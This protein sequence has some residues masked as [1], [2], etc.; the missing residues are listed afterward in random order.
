[1][2]NY[3][4]FQSK[5]SY[6]PTLRLQFARPSRVFMILV[7]LISLIGIPTINAKAATTITFIA[8][9]FL[10]R[11]ADTSININVIPASAIDLYYEYKVSSGAYLPTPTVS[12]AAGE[13]CNVIISDLSPDTKYYYHM[14]YHVAGE[15]DW[16][17]RSEHSFHTQRAPGE[18]FT[19]VVTSDTHSG[20]SGNYF[21]QSRYSQTLAHFLAD[22]PDLW[23]DVGDSFATDYKSTLAQ[24]QTAY[25]NM[26][27]YIK[28]VS[29]D[30]PFFQVLG[31][32]E[33][34]MGWNLDDKA[35]TS[36]T[37]P[38]LE[39]N[40]RR[41]IFPNPKPDS[42]YSGNTDTSL[43]Y[44]DDDHLRE[45]YYAFTWGDA[46]FI[47]LDPYWYTMTWPQED[48]TYP[49]G[50]EEDTANETR[51][52]RWD[53][54]LG[55]DQYLWLKDTLE[56]STAL[57]KFIFIHHVT[58]GI[59]PYGRGGTEI[60]GYFE[61]GGNNWDGTW[62]WDTHRSDAD[63]RWTTPIHQLL[64]QNNVTML[65]H[66]HDHFYAK[67]TLD[68]IVYQEIPMP[69]ATDG[70]WGFANEQTS[71]SYVDEYPD[72]D[73]ILYY[74]GAE[75]YPN[76]GHLRVTVSPTAGVTVDYVDMNDGSITATYTI[77]TPGPS[78]TLTTAVAPAGGGA[79]DPS[80]GDHSYSEGAIV[81]VTATPASGYVF[82]HWDGD[83]TGTGACQVTMN[84]NKTVTAYFTNAPSILGDVNGDGTVN[85][86]DALIVLS[87]DV[88][89]DIS[90]FCPANC[91]DVNDDGLVNSTDALIILSYD[92][93]MS[94]P[95]PVGEQGCPASVTPCPGCNP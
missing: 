17:T 92:V 23:I 69:A 73:D 24:Y 2:N 3:F 40:A 84:A 67:Q 51:G 76:S 91:G 18:T 20:L 59:I 62:G 80:A 54:T 55:I 65:F 50:G 7:L 90:Q 45:D 60:A 49:F 78:Y 38:I 22:D 81:E 56:N 94:T 68:D 47:A 8:E 35:D 74:D 10:S 87:G 39:V 27:N 70:Y 66:G 64:A 21:S 95:F 63:A 79:I 4:L 32:H 14:K 89:I 72:P 1:M 9:E 16:V 83:C 86:T 11:P 93:G 25:K 85:S 12:A 37:Q 31:N 75:E 53:W 48:S 71:G 52:N 41:A 44:I 19:F 43:T 58:G 34:E 46:L 77:P 36:Q 13:P 15:T 30:V 29:G 61:W 42:F 33:Q 6:N 5:T 57:Y 82:N 88:G 28:T 26:R